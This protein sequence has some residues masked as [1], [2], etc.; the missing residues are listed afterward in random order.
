ML[1]IHSTSCEPRSGSVASAN[2]SADAPAGSTAGVSSRAFTIYETG[3]AC[4]ADRR[5]SGWRRVAVEP[6][7]AGL[8]LIHRWYHDA[9]RARRA[10]HF[11]AIVGLAVVAVSSL[12]LSATWST[13]G[14][15]AQGGD[16]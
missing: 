12:Q 13:A 15:K 5:V 3:T 16:Q 10:N 8:R 1:E 14:A 7:S 9:I 2:R 4:F 6:A 11:L